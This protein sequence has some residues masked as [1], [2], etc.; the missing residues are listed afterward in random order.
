MSS[1]R[2]K[3]WS[4][5]CNESVCVKGKY[6]PYNGRTAHERLAQAAGMPDPIVGASIKPD[7]KV[8]LRSESVNNSNFGVCD[9]SGTY[10]GETVRAQIEAGKVS[11]LRVV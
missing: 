7:G 11:C 8:E 10:A 6:K 4:V 1:A 5:V 2:P 9:A 3:G